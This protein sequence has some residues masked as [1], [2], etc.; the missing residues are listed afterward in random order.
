MRNMNGEHFL[1]FSES[2]Y[3]KWKYPLLESVR[4]LTCKPVCVWGFLLGKFEI[5]DSISLIATVLF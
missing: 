3:K 5:T 1:L 2:I 4:E